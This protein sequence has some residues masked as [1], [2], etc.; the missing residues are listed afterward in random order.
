MPIIRLG[1]MYL[2]RAEADARVAANWNLALTDVNT[3]R[4]RAGVPAL[5]SLTA[6]ELLS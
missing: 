6:D 5:G 4:A 3:I 2:I 1:D